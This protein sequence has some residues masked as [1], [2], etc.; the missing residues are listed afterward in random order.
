M[1]NEAEKWYRES[2]A[3]Y[4]SVNNNVES[5]FPANLPSLPSVFESTSTLSSAPVSPVTTPLLGHSSHRRLL[6]Q[7]NIRTQ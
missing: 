2:N 7:R 1:R 4:Q 5:Q 6:S 3:L